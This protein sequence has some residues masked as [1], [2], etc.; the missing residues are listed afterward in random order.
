VTELTLLEK[1]SLTSGA[2][3]W[4]T[5][6]IDRLDVPVLVFSDGPHGLRKTAS[7]DLNGEPSTAA[8]CFPPE[9]ALASSWDA[10]L[11]ERVG[12]AIGAEAQAAGVNVVLGPGVN[13][14]R[15]PLCGRNFEYLSEDPFLSGHLGAALIRGIQSLG[16]GASLKHFAV[17]NQET[18]RLR[19]S[20]E[21][22][23]RTLREIYLAAF[24]IAIKEADPWTVMCSYNRV[25]GTYASEHPWLLTSVLRDEWGYTGLVVSDWGA[26]NDRV[27][28]LRAGLDLEMPSSGGTTDAELVRAVEDG[29]LPEE[30]LDRSVLRFLR[31][32]GQIVEG[33][34]SPTKWNGGSDTPGRHHDLARQVAAQCVVLLKN[35]GTLPLDP[36]AS[37]A[38]I[39]ELARTPRLQGAGSSEVVPTRVDVPLDEIRRH[40]DP[41][42]PFAAGYGLEE[43]R[44]DPELE[45]EALRVASQADVVV[46][47]MGLSA[48]DESEGFDRTHIRLPDNQLA[49]F[50]QLAEANPRIV[51]VL[52]NG[53]VVQ[54]ADW[55]A[56]A[57]SII[58]GWL[59][60]QA[61]GGAIADVLFGHVN[62][63]GRLAETIPLRLEDTA[64]YV[65]FPGELGQ[66]RYGEGV[67]VGYRH[68]DAVDGPV[69]YPFGHGMSYTTFA[70]SD[71]LVASSGSD[72]KFHV[73]VRATVTNVGAR[74][75][76]EVVQLYVAPPPGPISR[77]RR[78]L[79]GFAKID[80]EPGAS[81]DVRF[82]LGWRDFAYYDVVAGG[83]Q[84]DP[85][86]AV[87]EVGASSRDIRLSTSV[88]VDVPARSVSITPDSPLA[89]WVAHPGG[90]AALNRSMT[91]SPGNGVN[92][93]LTDERIRTLG[94][95][96]LRR[97]ARFPGAGLDPTVLDQLAEEVNR[98]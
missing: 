52:S 15:S 12:A 73:E 22:D 88:D 81:T 92:Q 42:L 5:K 55:E 21:V 49:L 35:D 17:N 65:N 20:A 63:S 4:T 78:E 60:G 26:V 25:N 40:A 6:P 13:I 1:S 53:G 82:E 84:C 87:I 98:S 48:Q 31:L 70:Y 75:G 97:L 32:A 93:F 66:V 19:V 72:Q 95:F 56:G 23:E 28:A 38:V 59:L 54:V 46:L 33:R 30:I 74:P 96:P 62:P 11:I 7:G 37:I 80:V 16:V 34:L 77:P 10:D 8:T 2:G 94:G 79:R 68:H 83:W 61:G 90:R 39:G 36:A 44:R 3:L 57:N 86:R 27:A 69:S 47:F 24:E 18:D 50:D 67:F 89:E 76:Q 91:T 14:K 64:S 41:A 45:A 51:V 58:E 9:V 43:D 29:D 85:G 71:L